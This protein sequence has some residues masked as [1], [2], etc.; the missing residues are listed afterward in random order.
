MELVGE[1]ETPFV[2]R[3]AAMACAGWV[4]A[5]EDEAGDKAVE[6]GVGVV[7]VEE[8]LQ[9]VA[10]GERR[11]GSEELEGKGAGGGVEDGFGGGLWLEVVDCCHGGWV[12]G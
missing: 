1:G 7:A 4:A 10:G 5:L 8:V 6:E 3:L 9:E 11:L 12:G 2:A